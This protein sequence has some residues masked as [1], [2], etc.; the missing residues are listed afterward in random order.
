[1]RYLMIFIFGIVAFSCNS[2][3]EQLIA[4]PIEAYSSGEKVAVSDVLD[5]C[6]NTV[7][8]NDLKDSIK[9]RI[10]SGEDSLEF[11]SSKYHVIIW[12]D[13]DSSKEIRKVRTAW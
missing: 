1:M 3:K 10:K 7:V 11:R 9:N 12:M 6:F 13:R 4:H 5:E 2:K 8:D